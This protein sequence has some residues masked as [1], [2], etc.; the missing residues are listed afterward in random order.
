IESF[1]DLTGEEPKAIGSG[2]ALGTLGLFTPTPEH[3]WGAVTLTAEPL[4]A[5]VRVSG[6]VRIPSRNADGSIVL[7]RFDETDRRLAWLDHRARGVD[8]R[9]LQSGACGHACWIDVDGVTIRSDLVSRTVTLVPDADLHCKLDD[10][11]SMW[12]LVVAVC[13]RHGVRALRRCVR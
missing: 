10:Y 3:G 6:R 12:A 8:R 13:S 7:V 5:D 9:E 4:G 2:R 1:F 11:A